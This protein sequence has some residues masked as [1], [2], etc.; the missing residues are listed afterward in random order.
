MGTD[1]RK[2]SIEN[3]DIDYQGSIERVIKDV[4]DMFAI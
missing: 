3:L 2:S 1:N 4:E